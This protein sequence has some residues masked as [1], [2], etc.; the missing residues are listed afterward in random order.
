MAVTGRDQ[1]RVP[2]VEGWFTTGD[3]PHLMGRRCAACGTIAFPPTVTRCPNPDCGGTGLEPV[4]LSR[5]GTIWS[6]TVNHYAP[7]PPYAAADPFEPFGVAAVELSEERMIVLG[8]IAGDASSVAVGDEVELVV[9]AL[10]P[11]DGR[12]LVW[13]WRPVR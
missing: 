3:E 6:Y 13:K 4:E 5:R 8:Q 7:P 11:A 9:D 12:L 1:E 10:D 2:A